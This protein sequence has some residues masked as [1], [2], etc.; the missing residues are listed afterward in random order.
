MWGI[1]K[2][3]RVARYVVPGK[4]DL[5][6]PIPPAM[7]KSLLLLSSA[8]VLVQLLGQGETVLGLEEDGAVEVI[9]D[10]SGASIETQPEEFVRVGEEIWCRTAYREVHGAGR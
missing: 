10:E 7:K 4:A 9:A 1:L 2:K 6:R 5:N 3:F 8:A